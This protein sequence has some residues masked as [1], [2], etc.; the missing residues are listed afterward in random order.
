MFDSI[1]IPGE[2]GVRATRLIRKGEPVVEYRGQLLSARE[3]RQREKAREEGV[4]YVTQFRA[5]V[6][7]G[8]NPRIW[9]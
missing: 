4:S 1:L 9:L 5:S 7:A 3:G 6:P 2:R 8:Y